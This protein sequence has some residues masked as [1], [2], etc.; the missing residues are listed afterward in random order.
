MNRNIAFK[1]DATWTVSTHSP[2]NPDEISGKF[3]V[4]AA[5]QAFIWRDVSAARV[6]FDSLCG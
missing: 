2:E 6:E 1:P 4:I 3:L 5:K